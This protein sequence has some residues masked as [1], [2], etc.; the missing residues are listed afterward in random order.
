MFFGKTPLVHPFFS[1]LFLFPCYHR[2]YTWS[3]LVRVLWF[4]NPLLRYNPF[5]S[6]F[7]FFPPNP[8]GLGGPAPEHNHFMVPP[9]AFF[10]PRRFK[11]GGR[12]PL[13]LLFPNQFRADFLGF[14]FLNPFVH[15]HWEKA[16]VSW[17]A[18][19]G[20]LLHGG[21]LPTMGT[22]PLPFPCSAFF[23]FSP[24]LRFPTR[25]DP[26]HPPIWDCPLF[27][28]SFLPSVFC[29]CFPFFFS[30]PKKLFFPIFGVCGVGLCFLTQFLR[31]GVTASKKKKRIFFFVWIMSLL[32]LNIS[33]V[34]VLG[35]DEPPPNWI[36][37][38][39]VSRFFGVP[40]CFFFASFH[41]GFVFTN[42]SRSCHFFEPAF[43]FC[44]GRP[45]FRGAGVFFSFFGPPPPSFFRCSKAVL[46]LVPTPPCF[47]HCQT[48]FW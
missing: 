27:F 46:C 47:P 31:F 19:C 48:F 23:F 43:F 8:T 7:F 13:W 3:T 34:P 18:A 4:R 30:F 22:F 39:P 6:F 15:T 21:K 26:A 10:F 35:V 11:G 36:T 45:R 29:C 44:R 42:Q 25:G 17:T 40:R 38:P 5:F 2:F 32:I 41:R 33:S 9:R 12:V 20:P 1:R 37:A 14:R 28:L 16:G 24:F